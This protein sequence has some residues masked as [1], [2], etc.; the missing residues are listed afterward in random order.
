MTVATDYEDILR[1]LQTYIDGSSK[2]DVGQLEKVFHEDCRMY[3]S[4]GGARYDVPIAEFMKMAAEMPAD[5]GSYDGKI[6]SVTKVGDAAVAIVAE[7]GCWGSVTFVDFF[8]LVRI[9]EVW[10]VVNKCFA[11][12]A[13]EMPQG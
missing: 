3:G 13:G 9:G 5:T 11:H 1:V 7:E 12:T 2:G 4:A 6:T 8:S 10:K